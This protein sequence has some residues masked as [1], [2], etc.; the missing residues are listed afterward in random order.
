MTRKLKAVIVAVMGMVV[1][2]SAQFTQSNAR[3]GSMAGIYIIDDISDVYRYAARMNDFENDIQVTFSTPMLGIKSIGENFSAGA[4]VRNGLLLDQ[5]SATENFYTLGRAAVNGVTTTA[6]DIGSDPTYIPH[7]LLGMSASGVNIGLDIFYEWART[8][9]DDEFKSGS[10]ATPTTI[11]TK[12]RARISNIGLIG[13]FQFGVN[14]QPVL[15]KV[16]FGLPRINGTSKVTNETSGAAT[17][18]TESEIT[19]ESGLFLELGGEAGLSLLGGTVTPGIDF[20]AESYSFKANGSD[21]SN[22][23]SNMR[24]AIYAGIEKKAFDNGLWSAMYQ[25][26]ILSQKNDDLDS[27]SAKDFRATTLQQTFSAGAE[28]RWDSVWFFDKLFFRGGAGLNLT[29]PFNKATSDTADIHSKGQTV[30]NAF[31][32]VGIGIAKGI[33]E[34]DAMVDLANWGGLITGPEVVAVT[35]TLRF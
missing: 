16:G 21:A 23:F 3:I 34:L 35:G 32:T 17:Q 4:Y 8:R 18:T 10:A 20:V 9:F 29:T 26:K 28:N 31:P 25:M 12:E 13:S 11:T 33:F 14:E 19:S 30:F 27:D 1:S 7:L 15:L 6:P 22:K 5:S 24:C 2:S